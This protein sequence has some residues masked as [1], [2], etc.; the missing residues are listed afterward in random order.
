MTR[1][2]WATAGALAG[3]L[4]GSAGMA[5]MPVT[6][7][8]TLLEPV[9]TVT[10]DDGAGTVAVSFEA[11]P[12]DAVGTTAAQRPVNL[13]VACDNPAPMGKTLQMYVRPG[14]NGILSAVGTNVLGTSR[15]GLGIALTAGEA[16]VTL[17][18]WVPVAGVDTR[19]DTPEGPLTL[20][21]QLVTPSATTLQAGA[22]TAT[23]N[24]VVSYR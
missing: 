16:P 13:T 10:G 18:A 19:P 23:A 12:L 24:L 9:C 3:L 21:A 22:F 2:R 7:K 4:W 14:G 6:I 8:G 20:T 15:K 5:D 11:T 17:N 1:P